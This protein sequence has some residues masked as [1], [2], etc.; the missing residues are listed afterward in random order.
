MKKMFLIAALLLASASYVDAGPFSRFLNRRGVS[1]PAVPFEVS[2]GGQEATAADV[3]IGASVEALD[4]VNATRASRGLRP[5]LRDDQLTDAAK[6]LAAVRAQRRIAG[7]YN[8]FFYGPSASA[9]GC[10]ALEPSWGWGTCCTYESWTYAGA[11]YAVGNDGR[12][13]MH[14]FVR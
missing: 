8:D 13:Y 7:H 4:E 6:R 14:L 3:E 12:R 1:R 2:D 5:F 9:A 11:A 10:G